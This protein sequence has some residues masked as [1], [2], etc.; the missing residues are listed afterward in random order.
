MSYLIT[1]KDT[2][3]YGSARFMDDLDDAIAYAKRKVTEG[4]CYVDVSKGREF[5]YSTYPEPSEPTEELP[6]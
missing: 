1:F 4:F 2:T 6:F 3:C 5:Y